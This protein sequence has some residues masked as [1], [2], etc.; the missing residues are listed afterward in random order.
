MD[1]PMDPLYTPYEDLPAK[2]QKEMQKLQQCKD[3]V[4][5]QA[6]RVVDVA[7][8]EWQEANARAELTAAALRLV[9]AL[10]NDC[11]QCPQGLEPSAR[12]PLR[13]RPRNIQLGSRLLI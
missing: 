2:L 5:I 4:I 7:I 12:E 13:R 9:R 10:T 6:R 3:R 11:E 8:T 1:E